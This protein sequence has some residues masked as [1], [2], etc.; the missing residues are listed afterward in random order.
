MIASVCESC[1]SEKSGTGFVG[2]GSARKLVAR[3]GR[4]SRE[5]SSQG[6]EGSRGGVEDEPLGVDC[7]LLLLSCCFLPTLLFVGTSWESGDEEKFGKSKQ[8]G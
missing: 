7:M 3:M 6:R 2:A 8:P 4:D 5:G 1:S